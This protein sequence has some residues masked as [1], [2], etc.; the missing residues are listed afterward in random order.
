MPDGDQSRHHPTASQNEDRNMTLQAG[1]KATPGRATER[2]Q[3]VSLTTLS[4]EDLHLLE[5]YKY[6]ARA[7][8][9][10][11]G[12]RSTS[13]AEGESQANGVDNDINIPLRN[14]LGEREGGISTLSA[15]WKPRRER[16]RSRS[17]S[18]SPPGLY[19]HASRDYI[20][21]RSGTPQSSRDENTPPPPPAA[22]PG[23]L[24]SPLST[25]QSWTPQQQHRS[26]RHVGSCTDDSA[27]L[28][29]FTPL[30]LEIDMSPFDVEFQRLVIDA[31][32][33]EHVGLVS[34]KEEDLEQLQNQESAAHRLSQ[35]LVQQHQQPRMPS[36]PKLVHFATTP[37]LS[38][39]LDGNAEDSQL[40]LEDAFSKFIRPSSRVFTPVNDPSASRRVSASSYRS[41]NRPFTP[42]RNVS[43]SPTTT[44]SHRRSLSKTWTRDVRASIHRDLTPVATKPQRRTRPDP[45]LFPGVI[46]YSFS[47]RDIGLRQQEKE[48][49]QYN[50]RLQN[51]RLPEGSGDGNKP[52][53]RKHWSWSGVS[54]RR[55]EGVERQ[56]LAESGDEIER[57]DDEWEVLR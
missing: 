35:S 5:E 56:R 3:G 6:R 38:R 16:T 40:E 49:K 31:A 8:S 10:V 20:S 30:P 15:G 34:G 18:R 4:S 51:V 27:I 23:K 12:S 19:K 41:T 7:G 53:R 47:P 14:L 21:L 28:D 37:S 42:V 17:R 45:A 29:I 36:R 44:S 55:D 46:P 1:H 33:D 43:Q 48:W 11:P 22:F 9:W 57:S 25:R 24:K 39:H 32:D 26:I 2:E 52:T 50:H 13:R 54:K